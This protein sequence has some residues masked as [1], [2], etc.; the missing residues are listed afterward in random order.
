MYLSDEYAKYLPWVL[1]SV[2]H[3]LHVNRHDD[4]QGQ[5]EAGHV[6]HAT[7]VRVSAPEEQAGA[8]RASGSE[9]MFIVHHRAAVPD[10]RRHGHFPEMWQFL[11]F[12]V[13]GKVWWP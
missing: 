9:G 11:K 5:Q 3:R 7:S 13:R 12:D 1:Q 6:G 10:G 2:F 4:G 8:E